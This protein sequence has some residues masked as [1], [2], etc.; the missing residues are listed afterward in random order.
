VE[1]VEE[2]SAEEQDA[3]DS[4]IIARMRARISHD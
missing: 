4:D 1:L 3:E 2:K